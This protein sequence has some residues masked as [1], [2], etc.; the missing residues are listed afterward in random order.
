M[1]DNIESLGYRANN[2]KMISPEMAL[3]DCLEN[4][5][6]KRGAFVKG[7]KLLIIALDDT[8]EEDYSFSFNQAGMTFSEIVVLIE[9]F[10][11]FMIE[12]MGF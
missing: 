3:K 7:K 11:K 2:A 6:G 10:K 9:V 1:A 12:E 5:I 4:D 8:D